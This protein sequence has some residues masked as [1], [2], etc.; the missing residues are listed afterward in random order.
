MQSWERK[1]SI[2]ILENMCCWLSPKARTMLLVLWGEKSKQTL[3][4][5]CWSTALWYYVRAGFALEQ[6]IFAAS[7]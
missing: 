7:I 5:S 2:F 3:I 4:F 1:A 6:V